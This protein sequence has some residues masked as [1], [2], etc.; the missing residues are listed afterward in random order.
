M[1]YP[2]AAKAGCRKGRG[3]PG[4]LEGFVLGLTAPRDG[5]KTRGPAAQSGPDLL[6]PS[7]KKKK[8]RITKGHVFL[9]CL[10]GK[11]FSGLKKSHFLWHKPSSMR[12]QT[13]HPRITTVRYLCYTSPA[14]RPQH[15]YCSSDLTGHPSPSFPSSSSC[16]W[17]FASLF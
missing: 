15:P 13:G 14:D 16:C 4:N 8:K 10:G 5:Q 6:L 1:V 2:C 7:P 12:R 11:E 9:V 17:D 3:D